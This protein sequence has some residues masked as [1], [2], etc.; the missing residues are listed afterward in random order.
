MYLLISVDRMELSI[1]VQA[2]PHLKEAKNTMLSEL[3]DTTGYSI[4]ELKTLSEDEA[5][6]D[7]DEA[8]VQTNA[9][10][11]VCWLI[12]DVRSPYVLISVDRNELNIVVQTFSTKE[13]AYNTMVAEITED[14]GY[15]VD[16]LVALS[17]SGEAY[18]S[19]DSAWIESSSCGTIVWEIHAVK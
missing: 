14:S 8:Y 6:I 3:E 1:A 10:G 5:H 18:I 11:T 7:E 16:E 9:Y 19:D 17:N 2:F 4:G 15:S 13:E 12:K